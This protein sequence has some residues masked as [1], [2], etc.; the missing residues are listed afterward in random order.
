[1]TENSILFSIF[2]LQRNKS[3]VF[4]RNEIIAKAVASNLNEKRK[5]KNITT[6]FNHF[7]CFLFD[8]KRND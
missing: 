7:S 1:S 5:N 6:Y 2:E 3:C 8:T 4:F